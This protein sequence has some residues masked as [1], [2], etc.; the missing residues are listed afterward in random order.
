MFWIYL[1]IIGTIGYYASLKYMDKLLSKCV[2]M[3][4]S[5]ACDEYNKF[6]FYNKIMFV[7]GFIII[8]PIV[9]I[10]T[11]YNEMHSDDIDR[12]EW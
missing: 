8:F 10:I 4:T 12:D 1:A 6:K 7:M 2:K 5:D 3:P 9:L 11:L